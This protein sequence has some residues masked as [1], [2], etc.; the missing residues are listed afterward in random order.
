[1]SSNGALRPED[2]PIGSPESRAAARARLD[3]RDRELRR[4]E[5]ISH[6][7][8]PWTGPGPEPSD[9]GEVPEVGPWRI[10]GDVMFRVVYQ[11]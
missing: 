3:G 8:R 9:W 1:M 4:V 5:I 10:F 2:F 7:P 6:I 11:P